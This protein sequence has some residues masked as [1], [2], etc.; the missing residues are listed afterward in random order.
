MTDEQQRE[1]DAKLVEAM[2]E[3]SPWS[4]KPWVRMALAIAARSI[5]R[6]RHLTEA[7]KLRNLADAMAAE[8][9]DPEKCGD[10]KPII[11]RLREEAARQE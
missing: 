9:I 11:D 1:H 2:I 7:E 8:D 3:Q 10:M 5:R 6:G 4:D